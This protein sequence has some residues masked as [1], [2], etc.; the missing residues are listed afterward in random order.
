MGGFGSG[1]R[2]QSKSTITD[3]RQLDVR[4]LQR[5]GFL[6]RGRTFDWQWKFGNKTMATVNVHRKSSCL[7]QSVN[8]GP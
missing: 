2:L 5:D 7:R 8:F 4:Q 1:R 6:K 3:Y